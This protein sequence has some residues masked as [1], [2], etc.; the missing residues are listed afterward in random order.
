MDAVTTPPD[1]RHTLAF[2]LN[3]NWSRNLDAVLEAEF[4][5]R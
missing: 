3:G 5:G 2:N 4:C 1:G